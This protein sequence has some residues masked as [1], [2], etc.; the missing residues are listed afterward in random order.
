MDPIYTILAILFLEWGY[1]AIFIYE[2]L[3]SFYMAV[4]VSHSYA[5]DILSKLSNSGYK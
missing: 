5:R 1:A 2:S 3:F 4:S